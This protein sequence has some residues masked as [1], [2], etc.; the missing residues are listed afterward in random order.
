MRLHLYRQKFDLR[1]KSTEFLRD[2][3]EVPGLTTP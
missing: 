3:K 1:T 2:K